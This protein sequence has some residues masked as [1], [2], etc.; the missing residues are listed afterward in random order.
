MAAEG[1]GQKPWDGNFELICDWKVLSTVGEGCDS[2][3]VKAVHQQNG[4]TV[5]FFLLL[6]LLLLL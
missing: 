4:T 6:P 5:C 1:V 2:K 3:V